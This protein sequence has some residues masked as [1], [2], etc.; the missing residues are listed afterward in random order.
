[1]PHT[2]GSVDRLV[3]SPTQGTPDRLIHLDGNTPSP[4]PSGEG[5]A[6][7]DDGVLEGLATILDFVGAGVTVTFNAGTATITISGG[8]GGGGSADFLAIEKW[9]IV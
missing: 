5:V 8:G 6:V 7:Y 4:T 3:V 2:N 9:S 1:M